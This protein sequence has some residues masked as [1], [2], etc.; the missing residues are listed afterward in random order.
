LII[1]IDS[2]TKGAYPLSE[3]Q[4]RELL[5]FCRSVGASTFTV[6]FLYAKG[7]ES[8]RLAEDFYGRLAP[9]SAGRKKLEEMYGTGFAEQ[10]CWS[11]TEGAIDRIVKETCGN[12][13]AYD[14][15]KLPEQWL[16]YI[17]DT[18]LLQVVNHEQELTLRLTDSQ[19]RSFMLLGIPYEP[20]QAK[21]SELPE[22]PA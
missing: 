1:H 5:R 14:L 13:M 10:E 9:F 21:Y 6:N 7:E 20:G 17:G 3:Q 22:N 2:S 18:I 16:V 8:E 19:F 15:L 4:T 11:L 12:L